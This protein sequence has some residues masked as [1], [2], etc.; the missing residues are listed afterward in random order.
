MDKVLSHL[1]SDHILLIG[2]VGIGVFITAVYD[3]VTLGII[4][5][6]SVL[7]IISFNS[8]N[9]KSIN[10]DKD[11]DENEASSSETNN[12]TSKIKLSVPNKPTPPTPTQSVL[13]NRTPPKPPITP[14]TKIATSPMTSPTKLSTP[15]PPS[16]SAQLPIKVIPTPSSPIAIINNVQQPQQSPTLSS[17]NTTPSSSPIA[18]SKLNNTPT[19]TTTSSSSSSSSPSTTNTTTVS[20]SSSPPLSI[21]SPVKVVTSNT[22]KSDAILEKGKRIGKMI[23]QIPDAIADIKK[24]F[25][26]TSKDKKSMSTLRGIIGGAIKNISSSSSTPMTAEEKEKEKKRKMIAQEILQTEKVYVQKLR[27]IVDVYLTPF[28]V[29]AT[30]NPHPPLTLDQIHSIFSE[31]LIIFNYNS[32]FYSKLDE[33]MKENSN[34]LILG[35]LFLSITDFLK[36]YSVYVNNYTKAMNTLEKVKKNPNVEALLQ[37]FQQNPACDS[38]D[39]NSLLIMPVQ[40]VPRY[41]LLLSELIKCTDPKNP[42]YEN[43]N[44]ALEKMKVLASVINENKREAEF[45]NKMYDIQNSLEGFN[46]GDFIHPSR[47]LILDCEFNEKLFKTNCAQPPKSSSTPRRYLLCN[48]ILVRTKVKG[49]KLVVQEIFNVND[50]TFKEML[51]EKLAIV[52]GNQ[53][54]VLVLK[55]VVDENQEEKWIEAI[56]NCKKTFMS[57]QNS[58]ERRLSSSFENVG[59]PSLTKLTYQC[60]LL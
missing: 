46:R 32:H 40:R 24:E 23:P 8:R 3:S 16:Q 5:Y 42:D 30:E 57:N 12:I 10:K 49:K 26:E 58:F 33:R 44:K 38:L 25:K 60:A 18:S 56:N 11:E 47:R 52:S 54:D 29:A 28:K 1:T 51:G 15:I 17:T 9:N 59:G 21:P 39:L 35:D 2:I 53:T 48:D 41:I 4:F 7:F 37:T 22:S 20:I 50:I 55:S 13:S 43:L 6:A 14:P 45:L 34:V 19:T 27:A 31:I 36:S